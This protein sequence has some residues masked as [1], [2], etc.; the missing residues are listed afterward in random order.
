MDGAG[1]VGAGVDGAGVVGAGVDGA[2]VVGAGVVGDDEVAGSF[3]GTPVP[4]NQSNSVEQ[5]QAIDTK[6]FTTEH[7][8]QFFFQNASNPYHKSRKSLCK[9]FSSGKYVW[10]VSVLGQNNQGGCL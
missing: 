10:L 9:F 5:L 2:G 1:V 8:P 3:V 6:N 7:C 4:R